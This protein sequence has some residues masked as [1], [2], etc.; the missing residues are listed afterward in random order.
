MPDMSIVCWTNISTQKIPHRIHVIMVHVRYILPSKKTAIHVGKYTV[1]RMDP[2]WHFFGRCEIPWMNFL[3]TSQQTLVGEG[4][5]I[6]TVDGS[7]IRRSP[8]GMVLKPCEWWD[9]VPTSNGAGFQPSTVS[10]FISI[11]VFLGFWW[12]VTVFKTSKSLTS[13]LH[14][15]QALNIDIM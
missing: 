3:M 11:P 10:W 15:T 7:E 5:V 9:K 12:R 13:H 1:R 6:F 14:G 4:H 2:S 8:P